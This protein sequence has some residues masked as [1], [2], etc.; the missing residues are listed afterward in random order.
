M[1][2]DVTVVFGPGEVV[3][4]PVPAGQPL[5]APEQGRRWLDQQ[6]VALDCEPLRASGKV[7]IADK[8][9]AIALSAGRQRFDTD[10]AFREA[11]AHAALAALSRGVVRVDLVE[12]RVVA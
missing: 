10:A 12:G 1:R 6:F 9:L 3:Q 7:L 5:D 4:I 11:Y 8:L 2:Q